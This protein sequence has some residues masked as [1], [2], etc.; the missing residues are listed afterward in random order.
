MGFVLKYSKS[1]K[2][3]VTSQFLLINSNF[4]FIDLQI[5]R[6]IIWQVTGLQGGVLVK[7]GQASIDPTKS[8]FKTVRVWARS[9]DVSPEYLL[10]FAFIKPPRSFPWGPS[11]FS[12]GSKLSTLGKLPRGSIHHAT[13]SAFPQIVPLSPKL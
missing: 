10:R 3:T 4:F 11:I 2:K 1:L 9:R 13:S 7:K 6:G 12:L 8:E 5:L